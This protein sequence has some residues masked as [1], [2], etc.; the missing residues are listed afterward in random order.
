MVLLLNAKRLTRFCSFKG[1]VRLEISSSRR[2]KGAANGVVNYVLWFVLRGR[3]YSLVDLGEG[4]LFLDQTEARGAEKKFFWR[5]PLRYLGIWMTA[6]P[7]PPPPP[8]PK[9]W[10]R[11]CYG[12][13]RNKKMFD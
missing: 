1:D 10:I 5:P 13:V 4:P 9:V 3:A 12:Q 7:S 11:H 8:Y 2:A 6:P